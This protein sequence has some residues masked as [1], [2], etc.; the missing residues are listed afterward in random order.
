MEQDAV[1]EY[2][3]VAAD[4]GWQPGSGE[5]TRLDLLG[6]AAR[7]AMG[8]GVDEARIAGAPSSFFQDVEGRLIERALKLEGFR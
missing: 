8:E 5:P 3:E 2:E 7:R 1:V 6:L 4:T